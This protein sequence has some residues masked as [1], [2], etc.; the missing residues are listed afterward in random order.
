M[1]KN[2]KSKAKKDRTHI[3]SS[4]PRSI[5]K[6]TSPK[7]ENYYDLIF[8]DYHFLIAGGRPRL[9]NFLFSIDT[10]GVYLILLVGL[11]HALFNV[12]NYSNVPRWPMLIIGSGLIGAGTTRLLMLFRLLINLRKAKTDPRYI[13]SVLFANFLCDVTSGTLVTVWCL[14]YFGVIDFMAVFIQ[15]HWPSI[16]QKASEW[17]STLIGW[18]IS[19]I[20]G[21]GAFALIKRWRLKIRRRQAQ[22]KSSANPKD[23]RR[24]RAQQ[25]IRADRP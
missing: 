19:G 23:S 11:S 7:E 14:Y 25:V 4:V 16:S 13:L 20:I 21:N 22:K 10:I 18:A 8:S 12:P 6:Y 9:R 2:R 1:K 15:S 24:R 5:P 17:I 3:S